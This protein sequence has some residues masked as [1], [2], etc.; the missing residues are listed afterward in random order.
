M[1]NYTNIISHFFYT[2]I[3]ML[4]FVSCTQEVGEPDIANGNIQL[5]IGQ[6]SLDTETRATPSVLGKPLAGN[7]DLLIQR[8]GT[9]IVAYDGSF[10]ESV[11]VKPGTYD[12]TATC[13]EDVR[14]GRDAPF[15]KG[16][17]QVA[18]EKDKTTSVTIPC[19][20]ANALISVRFGRD[21]EESARFEHHYA[22]YGVI[23]K[24]GSESM[25]ISSTE[26]ATSIYF[27]A[28][29][30]P[31]LSFYGTLR[32]AD[33]RQVSFDLTS[34][35]L[36]KVLNEAEHAIVTLTLPDPETASVID[37]STVDVETVTLDETIPLSW[38]PLPNVLAEH[39][40]DRNECLQGTDITFTNSYPGM[41]WKA[42]VTD[43]QGTLFRTIEGTGELVSSCIN[44]EDGWKYIPAGEYTATF[45]LNFDGKISKTGTRTFTVDNPNLKV[46]ASAYTSYSLYQQGNVQQ[47]NAC[48]PY[49]VYS[50]TVSVNVQS[51]LWNDARY[52]C[53]LNTTL[54]GTAITNVTTESSA[55]GT[56]FS[57]GNQQNIT[58]SLNG[59]E[60]MAS[61][62]FDKI[63]KNAS[64]V[65]YVTGLPANFAPPTQEHWSGP[66]SINWSSSEVQLTGTGSQSITSNKFA[67]P[68]GTKVEA[69]YKVLLHGGWAGT[70]LT[71]SFGTHDFF[72]ENVSGS[73]SGKDAPYED[74]AVFTT[75]ADVTEVKANNSYGTASTCSYIYYLNYHYAE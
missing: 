23:V 67:V 55:E 13:G 65:V 68:N 74:T 20:V 72:S 11:S 30:N 34:E 1:S 75:S 32:N 5:S 49:T 64:T 15:Y 58:P 60:L 17:A 6:I 40:Y 9:S 16:T 37:I 42:E 44:I 36:P 62:T 33:N 53:S 4:L 52:T 12:I 73:L 24:I 70:T 8:K 3:A 21:N 50:P 61:L 54:E 7:F 25:S 26:T 71:L 2:A 38:L 18:V 31:E 14:I 47:A 51:S 35:S 57:F 48:E 27:P 69:S 56:I 66:G 63:T 10:T 39:Y 41:E 22:D 28:G 19:R 46:T 59:C 43:A 45:Y 29:S